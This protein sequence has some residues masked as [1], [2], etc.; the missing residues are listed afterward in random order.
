MRIVLSNKLV[1][2]TRTLEAVVTEVVVEPSAVVDTVGDGVKVELV[3]FVAEVSVVD[4]G[5]FHARSLRYSTGM[6]HWSAR[7][8]PR[9][10][11][12]EMPQSM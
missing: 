5:E 1:E 4:D 12:T 8:I 7:W 10:I 6:F 9:I 11:P 3:T 2:G